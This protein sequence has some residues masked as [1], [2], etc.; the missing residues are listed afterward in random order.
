MLN[1]DRCGLFKSGQSSICLDILSVNRHLKEEYEKED[2]EKED[3][4]NENYA[5]KDVYRYFISSGYN[6]KYDMARIEFPKQFEN[7]TEL[8]ETYPWIGNIGQEY[9]NIC[10]D[11]ISSMLFS[12]ELISTGGLSDIVFPFYTVCCNKL[13]QDVDTYKENKENKLYQV[14]YVKNFPYA[15]YYQ[16]FLYKDKNSVKYIKS[17]PFSYHENCIICEECVRKL[18]NEPVITYSDVFEHRKHSPVYFTLRDLLEAIEIYIPFELKGEKNYD[19][20]VNF[21]HESLRERFKMSLAMYK[22]KKNHLLLKKELSKYIIKRNIDIIRTKY[23]ISKD[24][25]SM[26]LQID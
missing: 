5:L 17:F 26:M 18:R 9:D 10:D 24:I 22:S 21:V 16:I 12:K 7:E 23:F 20:I 14:R 11:C 6:S 25:V 13:F 4:E 3:Y 2:Y 15:S 8:R 1:C 19:T